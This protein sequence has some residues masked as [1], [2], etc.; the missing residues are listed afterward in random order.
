MR[1]LTGSVE[2]FPLG[3]SGHILSVF[4]FTTRKLAETAN[5]LSPPLIFLKVRAHSRVP[6]PSAAASGEL[7]P[8]VQLQSLSCAE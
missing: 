7:S 1:L 6:A 5:L 8:A 2:I 4:F 3:A